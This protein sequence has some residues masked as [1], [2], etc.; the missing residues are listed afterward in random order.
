MIRTKNYYLNEQYFVSFF[1]FTDSLGHFILPTLI[2]DGSLP[3]SS[4]AEISRLSFCFWKWRAGIDFGKLKEKRKYSWKRAHLADFIHWYRENYEGKS[5]T[6]EKLEKIIL[7]DDYLQRF[8]KY[9]TCQHYYTKRVFLSQLN[10]G[11]F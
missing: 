1:K 5:L 3:L 9:N 4:E 7:S 10:K 2:F 8:L 6:K 11:L